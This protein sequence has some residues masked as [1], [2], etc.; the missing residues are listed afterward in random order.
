M[1]LIYD[2]V[3]IISV[4]KLVLPCLDKYTPTLYSSNRAVRVAVISRYG[5]S[6]KRHERKL[7][8]DSIRRIVRSVLFV[9]RS[10]EL[11]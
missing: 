1:M 5:A 2:L 8:V 4:P 9:S 6:R 11:K 7:I 3:L 10:G